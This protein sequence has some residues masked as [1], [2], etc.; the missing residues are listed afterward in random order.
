MK[1]TFVQGPQ[2]NLAVQYLSSLLKKEGH[3]V[4]LV[5]DPQLFNAVHLKNKILGNFF[6]V[7]DLVVKKILKSKPDLVGFSVFTSE[8]QWALDLARR[9]KNKNKKMPII[10]GGIHP[11][12]V[13]EV[14]IKEEGVDIVCVGE[15][16]GALLELVKNFGQKRRNYRIKNLWFKKNGRVIKNEIRPLTEDLDSLP[17]PD[18]DLFFSQI[19]FLAT[20]YLIM[21]TRGCP[22]CCTYCGNNA[23][24][25]IYRGRG[26]YLRIRSVKS[27]IEE[28]V[29]A[30]RK[31]P[32]LK[33]VGI[34]DDI[35]PLNKEWMREFIGRYKKEINLPFLCYTHPR[36][37]DEEIAWLLKEGGCFWLSMGLQTASEK[38]RIQLLKRVETN[39]EVRQAVKYCHQVGL[40]FSL[41]HIFGIPF[42][43]KKEYIEGLKFYNELRPSWINVFWLVY[44]PKTEI[45]ELGKKAGYIDEETEKEINEGK[46]STCCTLKIGGEKDIS[47]SKE[48]E[49]KNFALLYTLLPLIPRK[50]MNRIIEKKWY[51]KIPEVSGLVLFLAKFIVRIP[52]GQAYL[53]TSELKRTSWLALS[54]LKT[55]WLSRKR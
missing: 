28:L 32:K 27:V 12:C 54:V 6:D 17:F 39:T 22:Y 53:Y 5:I 36:Y 8:Y 21:A 34:P 55:K 18:K 23:K 49:F 29:W 41:D 25:K 47:R 45:I 42:E 38:N 4:S 37:I 2:E 46:V 15:G 48:G 14:V 20:Y 9:I 16:E 52:I 50:L 26:K 43:G 19:P 11:T 51:K 44:F 30:K 40:K 24:A 13:P 33:M 10:F 7:R 3:K 35:L 1:I 31:Y